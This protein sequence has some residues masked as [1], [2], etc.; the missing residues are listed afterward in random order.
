MLSLCMQSK[1]ARGDDNPQRLPP[2]HPSPWPELRQEGTAAT[3][4]AQDLRLRGSDP[5]VPTQRG[6]PRFELWLESSRTA[7]TPGPSGTLV[8]PKK[9]CRPW[10]ERPASQALGFRAILLTFLL[11]KRVTLELAE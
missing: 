7:A 10:M 3:E 4:R 1:S 5:F 2:P 6:I 8:M 9:S 11:M